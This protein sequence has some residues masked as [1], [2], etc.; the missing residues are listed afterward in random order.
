M[1]LEICPKE[2]FITISKS[3]EDILEAV[4]DQRLFAGVEALMNEV[5]T[6]KRLN[7]RENLPVCLRRRPEHG[8]G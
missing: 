4:C 6:D 5:V 2:P 3:K 8:A 7:G 1:R